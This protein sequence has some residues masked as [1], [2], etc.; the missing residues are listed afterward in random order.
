MV[1]AVEPSRTGRFMNFTLKCWLRE[2]LQRHKGANVIRH[3]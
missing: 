1:K 2:Q 3:F